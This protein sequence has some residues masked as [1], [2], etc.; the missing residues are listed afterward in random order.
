MFL[1]IYVHC[2]MSTFSLLGACFNVCGLGGGMAFKYP[3]TYF[4]FLGMQFS[5][6]FCTPLSQPANDS[7]VLE[8]ISTVMPRCHANLPYLILKFKM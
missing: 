2:S 1:F 6:N 3:L 8:I 5:G 7:T 4:F